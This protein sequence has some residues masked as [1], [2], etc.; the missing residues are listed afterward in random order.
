MKMMITMLVLVCTTTACVIP[1]EYTIRLVGLQGEAQEEVVAEEEEAVSKAPPP[2]P[3][4][5]ALE[6]V[7]HIPHVSLPTADDVEEEATYEEV[8]VE[9]EEEP[10]APHWIS[11]RPRS[12][13]AGKVF[14]GGGWNYVCSYVIGKQRPLQTKKSCFR[15]AKK[16]LELRTT[17]GLRLKEQYQDGEIGYALIGFPDKEPAE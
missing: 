8:Y 15:S 12:D 5:A 6:E 14:S 16:R 2:P 4:A 3:P 7:E 9:E 11:H 1:G 13:H 17:K 10:S